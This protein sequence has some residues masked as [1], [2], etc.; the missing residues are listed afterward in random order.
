MG[1]DHREPLG[2]RSATAQALEGKDPSSSA[3]HATFPASSRAMATGSAKACADT[4]EAPPGRMCAG[5]GSGARWRSNVASTQSTTKKL[6]LWSGAIR[7]CTI[8]VLRPLET[9]AAGT[10][11]TASATSC[12]S[13]AISPASCPLKWN[14]A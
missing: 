3:I 14:S 11:N 2:R 5:T 1:L 7:P 6:W 13:N 10:V 4:A 9:A 8:S 12:P